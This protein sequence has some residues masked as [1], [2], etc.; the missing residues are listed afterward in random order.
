MVVAFGQLPAARAF[1][2]LVSFEPFLFHAQ[3]V[4][5]RLYGIEREGAGFIG[6]GGSRIAGFR[7]G[8][9]YFRSPDN[10]AGRIDN[11]TADGACNSHLSREHAAAQC[12]CQKIRPRLADHGFRHRDLLR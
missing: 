9:R 5:V 12:G 7:T 3:V 10:L 6:G 4:G 8:D 1:F 11:R 2:A